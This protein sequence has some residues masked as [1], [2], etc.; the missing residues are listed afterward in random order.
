LSS[1]HLTDFLASDRDIVDAKFE[2]VM[3]LDLTS[4]GLGPVIN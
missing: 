2:I 1:L 4:R 3:R